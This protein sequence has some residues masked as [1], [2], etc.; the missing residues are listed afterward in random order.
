MQY[1][2]TN[3]WTHSISTCKPHM[4]P[5]H[6]CNIQCGYAGTIQCSIAGWVTGRGWT[7][8]WHLRPGWHA[9]Y[10]SRGLCMQ[11]LWFLVG[12]CL[13]DT[14]LGTWNL[15]FRR[16][17][18]VMEFVLGLLWCLWDDGVCRRFLATHAMIRLATR[19]HS[20]VPSTLWK[21]CKSEVESLCQLY[22][23]N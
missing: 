18:G 17:C 19:M 12:I 20:H 13:I 2:N 14:C 3:T 8:L 10:R 6:S 21:Y 16:V 9:Q 4:S 11:C 23:L 15:L 5:A 22:F 7:P 1:I